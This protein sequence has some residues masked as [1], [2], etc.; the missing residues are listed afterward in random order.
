MLT[1]KSLTFSILSHAVH[2][3]TNNLPLV[4]TPYFRHQKLSFLNSHHILKQFLF[5]R[6]P[7]KSPKNFTV[8][9]QSKK[10]KWKDNMNTKALFTSTLFA[11]HRAAGFC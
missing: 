6:V 10:F 4:M 3:Q 2:S 8:I 5:G 7:K 9:L 11:Q 1:V